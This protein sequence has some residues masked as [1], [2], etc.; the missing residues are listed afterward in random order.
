MK[1]RLA[2]VVG[3]LALG[4]GCTENPSG[5]WF[6]V[7]EAEA[8]QAASCSGSL[9]HNFLGAQQPED[10]V[11]TDDPWTRSTLADSSDE[12]F[13]VLFSELDAGMVMVMDGRTYRA[14]WPQ[15]KDAAW[16]FQWEAF[17]VD[18]GEETHNTGYTWK[19]SVQRVDTTGL[20]GTFTSDAFT[21]TLSSLAEVTSTWDE[22]DLWL[23]DLAAEI[24]TVGRIP[25]DDYLVWPAATYTQT[26]YG[27]INPVDLPTVNEYATADCQ[28]AV[29]T[30]SVYEACELTWT[31][32][33][34][35]TDI[36][37][38]DFEAVAGAGQ[39]AGVGL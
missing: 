23:E 25:S 15:G 31:V 3:L 38:A 34:E 29:C 5:V 20:T 9:S 36:P 21:G 33:G 1:A 10:A 27:G 12:A 17:Q 39:S 26:A 19:E 8:S 32:T 6:V 11:V 37:A 7:L 35:R 2:C 18:Q 22:A 24:G 14:E 13:F 28:V 30:L 16:R 4:T